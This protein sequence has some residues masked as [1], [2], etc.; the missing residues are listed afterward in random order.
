M[1][2][3][4][5]VLL[6]V[7]PAAGGRAGRKLGCAIASMWKRT[8]IEVAVREAEESDQVRSLVT[9]A[10]EQ[11]W[12]T[13]VALGGDGTV[14]AVG[15]GL[16]RLPLERRPLLG[17]IPAG[18]G[19]SLARDL[20]CWNPRVAMERL[21]EP[22]ERR[23]DVLEVRG[24]SQTRHVLTVAGWGMWAAGNRRAARL[25][26]WGRWRYDL[27]ALETIWRRPV[28]SGRLRCRSAECAETWVEGAFSLVVACNTVHSGRGLPLAPGA[29]FDDG[30]ME[31]LHVGQLPRPVLLGLFL[32]LRRGSHLRSPHVQH[33][34]ARELE[35]YGWRDGSMVLDG[36]AV[37]SDGD[38]TVRILPGVL[39]VAGTPVTAQGPAE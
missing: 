23:L 31:V 26:A 11:G 18:T 33:I 5:R 14:H 24:G 9:Q 38:C 29:R 37:A 39:R 3:L 10:P 36:E 30:W 7:N 35:L 16:M 19:N 4:K 34:R 17:V 32:Q 22:A 8:G 27:A 6:I 12:E 13:V 28:W 20:G 2:R 15:E 21:L 25:R 1:A